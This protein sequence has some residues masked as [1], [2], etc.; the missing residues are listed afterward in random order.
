MKNVIALMLVYIGVVYS[1]T[2]KSQLQ[3]GVLILLVSRS[4]D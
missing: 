4:S 2:E 1:W 3:T